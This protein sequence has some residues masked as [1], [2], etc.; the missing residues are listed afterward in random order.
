MNSSD[1]GNDENNA[2]ILNNGKKFPSNEPC[3]S[4][5]FEENKNF[6]LDDEKIV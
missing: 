1:G 6:S 2:L 3:S 5:T 4:P